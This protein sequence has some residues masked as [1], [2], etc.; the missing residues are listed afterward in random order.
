LS[1]INVTTKIKVFGLGIFLSLGL[2]LLPF[3][4]CLSFL[5]YV[6]WGYFLKTKN[7]NLKATLNI[8]Q[9]S[10][11]IIFSCLSSLVFSYLSLLNLWLFFSP[12]N[13]KI[14]E[15]LFVWIDLSLFSLTLENFGGILLAFFLTSL[16]LQ[17]FSFLTIYRLF[18]EKSFPSV[19]EKS[20]NLSNAFSKASIKE[21]KEFI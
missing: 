15:S 13:S 4:F 2:G 10:W 18:S 16:T 1:N 6:F 9:L 20:E 7:L 19:L 21:L 3:S 14:K 8:N 5:P 17:I 11:H 12:E